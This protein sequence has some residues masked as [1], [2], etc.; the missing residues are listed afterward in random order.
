MRQVAEHAGKV[1]VT[2]GVELL[3]RFETYLR[4]THADSARF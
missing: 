1:F 2:L 3:N 4:N